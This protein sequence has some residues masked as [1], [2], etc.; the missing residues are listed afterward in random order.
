MTSL[1]LILI[2]WFLASSVGSALAI[3]IVAGGA[4]KPDPTD[5]Y[6]E[7]GWGGD[8][9]RLAC[10][11]DQ[12]AVSRLHVTSLDDGLSGDWSARSVSR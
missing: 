9:A 11:L 3:L 7:W 12:Q 1:L 8:V 5:G 2:V 6:D 10:W 4:R